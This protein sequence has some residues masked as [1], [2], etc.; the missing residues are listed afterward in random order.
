MQSEQ[1][2][3]Q[4]NRRQFLSAMGGVAATPFLPNIINKDKKDRP[5]ILFLL[6]DDMTYKAIGGL[7]N[8][9]VH[10]PNL[11]RL[12]KRGTTF[13]HA[14]NEGAWTGAVCLPAR[15]MLISGTHLWHAKKAFPKFNNRFLWGETF[16]AHGYETYFTG[17]WHVHQ[18]AAVRSAQ[19]IGPHS[20]DFGPR[21]GGFKRG[22]LFS[23]GN[24]YY[25]PHHRGQHIPLSDRWTKTQ[26]AL[27]KQAPTRKW[28]PANQGLAGHWVVSNKNLNWEWVAAHAPNVNHSSDIWTEA[29]IQFLKH[30]PGGGNS[31][32]FMHVAFFSPHDPRQSPAS[33]LNRY[34]VD[35]IKVPPNFLPEFPFALGT[36]TRERYD[37]DEIL[38]PFP[39]T[40]HDIQVHR[41]EYY[42]VI[43]Y[44]DYNIGRILDALDKTGR[45]DNTIIIFTAD[46]GLSVGQHGLMGKQNLFDDSVRV[47]LIM[48]GPGIAKG[49][50]VDRRIY[51]AGLFP[52]TCELAGL[53][54]P[55]SV[56]K[57]SFAD[58]ASGQ[59]RHSRQTAIYGAYRMYQ[60]SIRTTRHKLIEY[61]VDGQKHTH[62]FDLQKNP[63]EKLSENLAQNSSYAS[64]LKDLRKKLHHLQKK[65]D[66]P[67]PPV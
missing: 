56:E 1:M 61:R 8:P 64:L 47:P 67:M 55:H 2:S 32:L 59:Q 31:P 41:R 40:E 36:R 42:A 5:N 63:W 9:E 4:M 39:R 22:M 62:L 35:K 54:I 7:N 48:A 13:T 60:R 23:N 19:Y 66:D 18:P 65:Y 17:K 25:R 58:L 34:P 6:A 43:S 3:N 50:K 20:G 14:F 24:E 33:Y 30:P 46:H 29:A 57:K 53:P 27:W 16:G 28:R 44:V 52:T 11:D 51:H 49:H 26:N 10:T 45:A 21:P 38:A 15:C 37:R 12:M